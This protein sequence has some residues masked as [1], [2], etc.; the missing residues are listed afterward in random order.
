MERNL[1]HVGSIRIA[2]SQERPGSLLRLPKPCPTYTTEGQSELTH[3]RTVALTKLLCTAEM[4]HRRLRP[5]FVLLYF[6]TLR[7]GARR[8]CLLARTS[9]ISV[10][11]PEAAD[12]SPLTPTFGRT[13]R[14][15]CARAR[16][17]TPRE[18]NSRRT[19]VPGVRQG[20][21]GGGIAAGA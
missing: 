11:N 13:A 18:S 12:A 21:S 8:C 10:G 15:G 5:R 16:S 19:A 1:L 14:A 17:C 6:K 2:E 20:A 7:A 4:G 9:R 3:A